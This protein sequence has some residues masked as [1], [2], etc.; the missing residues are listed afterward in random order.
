MW[1]TADARAGPGL[2]PAICRDEFGCAT[3]PHCPLP[4]QFITAGRIRSHL[5][6]SNRRQIHSA[7]KCYGTYIYVCFAG[8]AM[9]TEASIHI[10]TT[11]M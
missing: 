6:L 4:V 7:A 10:Y 9:Y 2:E 1:W 11:G 8:A 5:V 3:L